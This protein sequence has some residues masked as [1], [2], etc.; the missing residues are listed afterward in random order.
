MPDE[1]KDEM[2][3]QAEGGGDEGIFEDIYDIPEGSAVISVL[4][5]R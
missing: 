3:R 5:V 1:L 4:S 2:M